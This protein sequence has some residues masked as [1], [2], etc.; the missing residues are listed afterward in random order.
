M[1]IVSAFFTISS[2]IVVSSVIFS[3]IWHSGFTKCEN[4][5][6]TFFPFILIAP[7]SIILSETGLKPVVSISNTTYSAF[8]SL[9]SVGFSTTGFSS[10]T[11]YA[12]IPKITLKFS[13]ASLNACGNEYATPK[14]VIAIP[15]C[16][17][18]LARS[19]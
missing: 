2:V 18:C 12:S 19:A 16:P 5:P 6:I 1:S 8:S 10:S 13:S 7:I 14:S 17:K 4:S 11:I 9:A 3:G 15:L